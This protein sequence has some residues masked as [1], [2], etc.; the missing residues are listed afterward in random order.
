MQLLCFNSP[1]KSSS[2]R[3]CSPMR[4]LRSIP[5]QI[6][7]IYLTQI[8][9]KYIFRHPNKPA[10]L[11]KLHHTSPSLSNDI[12]PPP[13]P[14]PE[15]P[16]PLFFRPPVPKVLL[17]QSGEPALPW[18]RSKDRTILPNPISAPSVLQTFNF[19]LFVLVFPRPLL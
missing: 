12:A 9:I 10:F 8:R 3:P 2:D 15:S 5:T 17:S 11:P 4:M 16:N 19:L 1:L 13:P 6:S 14:Q 7:L 18:A